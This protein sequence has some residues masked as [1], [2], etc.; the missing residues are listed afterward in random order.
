MN[1]RDLDGG[2]SPQLDK[3]ADGAAARLLYLGTV[4][5][6]GGDAA[7]MEAQVDVLEDTFPGHRVAVH[8]NSTDV[9]RRLYPAWE[10]LPSTSQVINRSTARSKAAAVRRRLTRERVLVAARLFRRAPSL[11]G[12]LLTPS[13]RRQVISIA[14]A[15]VVL[16]TGGTSLIE[17]YSLANKLY[18]ITLAQALGKRTVLL[19]QS[20]GP[21]KSPANQALVRA[22][23]GRA[24]AVLLRDTRS[25]QHLRDIGMSVDRVRVVPDIVFALTDGTAVHRLAQSSVPERPRVCV[26]VRDCRAFFDKDRGD[27]GVQQVA[28]E[29]A[30][31][32]LVEHLVRDRGASVT[33]MS[34][35]QGVPEYWT[36]DSAVALSVVARLHPEVAAKVAVDR[37]HRGTSALRAELA[38]F[39]LAVCTRLHAA[40]MS[41][42]SGTPVLPIAYEFKTHEVM[43]QLGLSAYVSDIT[44][45]TAGDLV[46]RNRRLVDDLPH[47]RGPV[48]SA[49]EN[50]SLETRSTAQVVLEVASRASGPHAD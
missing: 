2:Q 5:S 6:N 46:E 8:D 9:A 13:E 43:R 36:D 28:F 48:S 42:S 20:V 3:T 27:V 10:V 19:P 1:D 26:S 34:T 32:G 41:L 23:L 21:F 38:R 30:V 33:F 44:G 49:L 7:I 35:C 37:K 17:K 47:L 12:V 24:D 29:E 40:I 18:E 15:D 14:N 39:D 45:I 31:A 11:A 4:V 50:M 22:V 25:E 16:Y